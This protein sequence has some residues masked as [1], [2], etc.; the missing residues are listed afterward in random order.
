V[1]QVIRRPVGRKSGKSGYREKKVK[2]IGSQ[3]LFVGLRKCT[4]ALSGVSAGQAGHL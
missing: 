1:Y 4:A 3:K 2:K